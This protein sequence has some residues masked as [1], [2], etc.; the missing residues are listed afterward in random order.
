MKLISLN[1]LSK[2]TTIIKNKLATKQNTLT[3]GRGIAITSDTISCT[4][5]II[6]S[7]QIN[8]NG[9]LVITAED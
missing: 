5:M 1:N 2:Y 9:E 8:S 4:K 7:V 3:A 6:E